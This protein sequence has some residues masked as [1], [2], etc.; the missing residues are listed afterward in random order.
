M[1][2]KITSRSKR[3][4]VKARRRT[5]PK[6][7]RFHMVYIYSTMCIFGLTLL[8]AI[9]YTGL[10]YIADKNNVSYSSNLKVLGIEE[11]NTAIVKQEHQSLI[12]TIIEIVTP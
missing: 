8:F 3:V 5:T 7:L 4:H 1:K 2:R 10:K 12:K 11:E 9:A 6:H